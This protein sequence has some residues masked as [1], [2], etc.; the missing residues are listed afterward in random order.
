VSEYRNCAGR[1]GRYGKRAAGISLLIAEETG[2][3]QILEREYIYG[4]PP[5]L[6]SAIPMQPELA[7][8]VLGVIAEQLANTKSDILDLF[9][10][11]FAFASFYQ[12]EGYENQMVEVIGSGIKQLV[13]M[14]LVEEKDSRFMITPLGRVA[15]RSGV[16]IMTFDIL[17]NFV[18]D[19]LSNTLSEEDIFLMITGVVEM[20]KLRPYSVVQRAKLLS[21]WVHGEIGMALTRDCSTQYSMGYGRIKDM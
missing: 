4:N 10:A 6:E 9:R 2:Q 12:S 1:A 21:R 15:A 5:K 13:A 20:E 19:G 7:R 18:R 11:S 8:Y 3:T 17:E 14:G 16:S